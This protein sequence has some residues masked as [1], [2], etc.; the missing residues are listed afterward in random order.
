MIKFLK[1]KVVFHDGPE[2]EGVTFGQSENYLWLTFPGANLSDIFALMSDK[3]KLDEIN[4]YYLNRHYTFRKFVN[5]NLIRM[6]YNN[7][8]VEVRLYGD[9]GYSVEDEFIKAEKKP[10]EEAPEKEAEA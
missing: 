10:E 5:L 2:M 9:D 4:A 3:S 1:P 6:T 8:A 7:E